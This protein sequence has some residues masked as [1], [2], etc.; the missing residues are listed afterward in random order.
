MQYLSLTRYRS[1][2]FPLSFPFALTSHPSPAFPLSS[3]LHPCPLPPSPPTLPL[4]VLVRHSPFV[5][6]VNVRSWSIAC[7]QAT[8]M[9]VT[10]WSWRPSSRCRWAETILGEGSGYPPAPT[11]GASMPARGKGRMKSGGFFFLFL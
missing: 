3:F 11:R 5:S 9:M 10:A 4:P 8:S 1:S 7:P 6:E 2:F